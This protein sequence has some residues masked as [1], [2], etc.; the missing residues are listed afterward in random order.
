MKVKPVN[1]Y[2][3]VNTSAWHKTKRFSLS[4]ADIVF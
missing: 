3:S 4:N 2:S 1:Y